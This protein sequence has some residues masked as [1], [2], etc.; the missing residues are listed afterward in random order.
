MGWAQSGVEGVVGHFTTDQ[1]VRAGVVTAAWSA[2][3][4]YAPGLLPRTPVQQAA[5]TGAAVASH[6]AIGATMWSSIA[7]TAAGLPG[8]RAGYRALLVAAGVSAGGGKALEIQLRPD[9]GESLLYG[10][11]WSQAKLLSVVGLA[12]GLVTASDVLLH[13]ALHVPRSPVTTLVLDLT[14]GTLMASGTW[15]RRRRRATRYGDAEAEAPEPSSASPASA[16]TKQQGSRRKQTLAQLKTA[17]FAAGTVVGTSIGLGVL[18]VGEQAAARLVSRGLNRLAGEDLGEF[19]AGAGHAATFAGF[20]GLGYVGLRMVRRRTERGSGVIEPA[21]QAPPE[22]PHVSTGPTSTVDF[23]AIG[24][25]GRRFVLMT[26]TGSEIEE[27]MAEP[28]I[29]PVRVVIPRSGSIEHRAGLAVSELLATGGID[30]SVICVAA[31]TGVGYVNYVMAEALEYLARGDCA[32]VVPQYAYVP[33][34]LALNKTDEGTALQRAVIEAVRAELVDRGRGSTTRVVQ[35]G[36]SLGAQVAADIGGVNGSWGFDQVGLDSGLYL[37]VPFRSSLW[38]SFLRNPD[39]VTGTGRVIV[40]SQSDE[41]VAGTR[42]HVMVCHHDDP[43]TK[44]SY[45]M[46]VQRPWWLGPPGTRPPGVPQETLF[47]PITSFCLALVDLLN[48]MN[49][50]PGAF[51]RVGHDYRIDMRESLQRTYRL[52]ADPD[53]EIRI[54]AAL[55]T[56]EQ[57]WAEKRLIAKTGERALQS[58]RDTINSWGQDTVNLQ[59]DEATG[60]R[61]SSRLVDYLNDRLGS[62]GTGGG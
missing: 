7:T 24:K 60:E 56:R 29:D 44:F 41:I 48:G 26:L 53:Q 12:G 20:A 22:N 10:A 23:D 13:D 31:P 46:A 15:L 17:A 39:A 59:L 32:I 62:G 42:P 11:A 21:Y 18:A 25:E 49:S 37:G 14:T 40:V 9:S 57:L 8:S 1:A 19:G 52:P 28:A 54:E 50:K 3:A 33:S 43:I 2:A 38:R 6:Y 30:R 35:F 4:S 51:R 5:V 47:R 34:A 45:S 61:A 36:E 58:V 27:V 16:A 55:R